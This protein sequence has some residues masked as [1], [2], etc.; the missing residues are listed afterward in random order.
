MNLTQYSLVGGGGFCSIVNKMGKI[1]LNK[2]LL[3]IQNWNK[4][5]LAIRNKTN[6]LIIK[7]KN[8]SVT[9]C[10]YGGGGKFQ[11]KNHKETAKNKT[12]IDDV[13]RMFDDPRLLSL[14][15][16]RK[17]FADNWYNHEWVVANGHCTDRPNRSIDDHPLGWLDEPSVLSYY[18]YT[19]PNVRAETFANDRCIFFFF[20]Y[21]L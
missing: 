6:K 13:L 8:V 17:W 16:Y 15:L 1:K 10:L 9:I 18:Y 19:K 21:L 14:Y 12:T 20:L 7:K 3:S 5:T 11:K 4:R 2:T